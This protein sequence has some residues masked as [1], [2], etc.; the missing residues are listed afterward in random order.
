MPLIYLGSAFGL[1][2]AMAVISGLDVHP[3][4]WNGHVKAAGY[5]IENWLPPAVDD[6][7]SEKNFALGLVI[8]FMS[9]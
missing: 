7:R 5:Y 2:L 8:S 6:P 3:D 9:I 1:I 4:E